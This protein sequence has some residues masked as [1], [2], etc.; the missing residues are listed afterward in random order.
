[1]NVNKALRV[2]IHILSTGELAA[3]RVV[4]SWRGAET[5]DRRLSPPRPLGTPPPPPAGLLLIEWHPIWVSWR[6]AGLDEAILLRAVARAGSP[7]GD[8]RGASAERPID[9]GTDSP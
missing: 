4:R 2:T 9:P 8:F 7:S 1:M 5:W 6:M 3:S